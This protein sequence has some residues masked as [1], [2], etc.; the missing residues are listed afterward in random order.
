MCV[1]CGPL[2]LVVGGWAA[3]NAHSK[4][5]MPAAGYIRLNTITN[6]VEVFA[7]QIVRLTL[8]GSGEQ[9]RKTLA[10]M[11]VD[12]RG[13]ALADVPW[14]VIS[15][16]VTSVERV[17]E[18]VD[19]AEWEA[20]VQAAYSAPGSGIV[21]FGNMVVNVLSS[22]GAY[23]ATALPRFENPADPAMQV[24]P[25]YTSPVDLNSGLGTAIA[26][27]ANAYYVPGMNQDM[28]RY[29]TGNFSGKP[30][31]S[32]PFTSTSVQM[33]VSKSAVPLEPAPGDSV[34]VLVTIRGGASQSTWYTMQVPMRVVVTDQRQWAVT[35]I[36]GTVDVGKIIHR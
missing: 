34:D 27:F 11:V 5:P 29:V 18:Q 21:Q 22:N 12:P 20:D 25:G 10:S 7:D 19:S 1:L 16:H 26:S 36:L 32:S 13:V 17:A 8:T 3:W 9:D 2:A 35:A 28:G 4:Q 14:N 30:L 15:T 24:G 6:Q 23:K 33:I 31:S